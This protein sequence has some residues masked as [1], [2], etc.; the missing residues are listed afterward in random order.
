VAAQ[1][2]ALLLPLLLLLMVRGRVH[3]PT[4]ALHLTGG[5]AVLR[6]LVGAV[7]AGARLGFADVAGV[8]RLCLNPP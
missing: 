4:Q 8:Q 2:D 5:S 3:G 6:L 1:A 7:P